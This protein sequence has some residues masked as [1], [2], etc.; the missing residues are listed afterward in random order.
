MGSIENTVILGPSVTWEQHVGFTRLHAYSSTSQALSPSQV[1]MSLLGSNTF[2][3]LEILTAD[4]TLDNSLEFGPSASFANAGMFQNQWEYGT[5]LNWVKGKHTLSFG[6]LWDHTQL[7]VINNNTATDLLEFT[8]FTSFVEG[9]I[10]S[11]E[12]F[13]GSANRYYR[14]DTVGAFVNDNYKLRSN[15]TLTLGLR[16]DYNGPLTEKNGRL[17]DFNPSLYSYDA[18]TDTLTGSGLEFA[19][20]GSD[21]LLKNLQAGFAPRI[22]I[23]YSPV[24]KLT[25]RTGFGIYY[26]RGEFFSY[27]SPSAGQGFNGPFGVTLA[28]PFVEPISAKRGASIADPFGPGA[29]PA[30]P[31]A[32]PAAFLSL[33]PNLAQT[34]SGDWPSGNLFGPFL[35]GGYDINNKLPY[36]ENW[37][38]DL[39]YQASNN[40]LFDAGYV[41]NHGVHQVL[42][43]PFNQPLLATPQNPVN[44]QIYSYGGLSPLS[45][46][47]SGTL[48]LEPIC[49]PPYYAGNA[50]IRVPYIG[51]DMNSVLYEGEGISNYNALQLQARK[52]LSKGLQL[53]ASYTWSKALDEQSGLGLFYT[54]DDPANPR[55]SYG[56]ADFDQTHVFLINYSYTIPSFTRSKL[57]G[58]FV[59]G[60]TL[61]GQTVA[62]SGQ[63]YSV[64]DYSG[65]VAGIYYGTYDEIT[66][67]I[68]PLA[69]G[70]SAK[71]AQ[72]QGTTGVNA[73][74]PVLNANDFLPQFVAPG[75][76]GVPPCD[77]TGCDLYESLFGNSGRNLFR[78]PFQT[79]F[80]VS[81]AKEFS[82]TERVHLR[83]EADAFNVFNHPDFDTP[84]NDVVFFPNFYGPP[85]IPPQGSLGY[86]QHTLGSSRFLQ[87]NLHLTF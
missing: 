80:D 78:G 26:D 44:G 22:G 5:T 17:T 70:T 8:N 65:S 27:L 9:S 3:Q 43:I 30:A 85:S 54:G 7:N 79:R 76:S 64:Y 18:G 71:Q 24:S 49:S 32:S 31:N 60:W 47:G 1:G 74:K 11:G 75:S 73:G 57:L 21:S 36:S 40:W 59:S 87:L 45:G 39:Q 42:P 66:N 77:A 62:Q 72:L 51:Y 81:L 52:R 83:F 29:A 48:D 16:W 86:I 10:R 46:C 69:P 50:E 61:G 25:L 13:T 38:F 20:N 23:A 4:P 84:N 15:L 41:G 55:S 34:T 37:T 35:F 19:K 33:L 53:T 56:P 68:V 58:E 28:P 14:S 67:P 12:A 6:G 2:P 82:V 63:P